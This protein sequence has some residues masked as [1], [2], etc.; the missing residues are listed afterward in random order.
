MITIH[1]VT[2]DRLSHLNVIS[3]INKFII[4]KLRE[5][6]KK[7]IYTFIYYFVLPL[8]SIHTYNIHSVISITD[9]I[10]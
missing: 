4:T 3:N 7:F 6:L 9:L 5:K 10:Y 2:I 8:N 1:V